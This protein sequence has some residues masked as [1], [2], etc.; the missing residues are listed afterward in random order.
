MSR[1]VYYLIGALLLLLAGFGVVNY[2]GKKVTEE[3]T[4]KAQ[5]LQTELAA[6][7]MRVPAT[8][9]IVRVLS[10]DGGSICYEPG[11]ALRRGVLY[12]MITNGAAGPGQ[13]PVI[14]DSRLLQGQMTIIKVYCPEYIETF[15][16]IV[17]DFTAAEG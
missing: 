15:Q 8:D 3:A 10:T 16:Q 17:D 2:Q 6:A 14:V 7:G 5:Q 13:R 9:Q 12:G 4:A 1:W 11:A